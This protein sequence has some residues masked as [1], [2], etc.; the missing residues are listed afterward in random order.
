MLAVI[1]MS[2]RTKHAACT[3]K[4]VCEFYE[5]G[6]C[7]V[8]SAGVS[9]GLL[10]VPRMQVRSHGTDVRDQRES[11]GMSQDPSPIYLWRRL[12]RATEQRLHT[13]LDAAVIKL[14]FVRRTSQ[15][16]PEADDSRAGAAQLRQDVSA[17]ACSSAEAN[18]PASKL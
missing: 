15:Q 3:A 18:A 8:D 11:D 2:R 17:A 13:H 4:Q 10:I 6:F 9:P 7:G 1:A 14:C 12:N 5:A 16:T